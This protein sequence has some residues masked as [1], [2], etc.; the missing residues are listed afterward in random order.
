[1][2]LLKP[3]PKTIILDEDDDELPV[4]KS[5]ITAKQK[6]AFQQKK[7]Q[8]FLLKKKRTQSFMKPKSELSIIIPIQEVDD[9]AVYILP[10]YTVAFGF[11]YKAFDGF[12]VA[13]TSAQSLGVVIESIADDKIKEV[14]ASHRERNFLLL[15][16]DEE[17]Y[18]SGQILDR[19]KYR[20]R[21]AHSIN[22]ELGWF[23]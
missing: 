9:D 16:V 4:V 1:M 19:R 14:A 6:A 20:T 22:D 10:T 8:G 23:K 17:F 3:K 2:K 5:I 13:N 11:K 12:A 7:T 15:K 21:T 18:V